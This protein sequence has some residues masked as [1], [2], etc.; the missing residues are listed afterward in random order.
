VRKNIVNATFTGI[1]AGKRQK[2]RWKM[3]KMAENFGKRC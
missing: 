3:E 2:L 1:Y